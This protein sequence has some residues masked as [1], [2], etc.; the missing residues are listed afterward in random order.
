MDEETNRNSTKPISNQCYQPRQDNNINH[1]ISQPPAE[2]VQS[3][4]SNI[5]SRKKKKLSYS[6]ICQIQKNLRMEEFNSFV[7]EGEVYLKAFPGAKANQLNYQ[8]IPII[9]GNNYD[10][11][12]MHVVIN[13]LVSSNKSV[14]DVCRD[15]I[16]IGLR[17]RS[18]SKDVISSITLQFQN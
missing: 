1:Y 6:V 10:A 15:I 8:T 5:V 2:A 3:Y 18:N 13:D 4:Y 12:A 17:Y 14:N 7:K 11:A 16:S 9:Q